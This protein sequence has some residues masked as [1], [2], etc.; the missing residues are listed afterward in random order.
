MSAVNR[1]WLVVLGA[2]GC[3][4]VFDIDRTRPLDAAIPIDAQYF[5]AP[6]DARPMCPPPGSAPA[7]QAGYVQLPVGN[8]ISYVPAPDSGDA[9]TYC[10]TGPKSYIQQGPIDQGVSE[11]QLSPPPPTT[12]GT[13]AMPRVSADGQVLFVENTATGNIDVFHRTADG[14]WTTAS[15]SFMDGSYRFVSNATRGPLRR[16]IQT[17]LDGVNMTYRFFELE[18]QP[19][20]AWLPIEEHPVTDIGMSYIDTVSLS[21]DGRHMTLVGQVKDSTKMGVYWTQRPDLASDFGEVVELT[22][23]PPGGILTPYITEDCSRIYF[24]ALSTVFYQKL[25]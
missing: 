21:P 11:A 9:V 18:E 17:D 12:G 22:T 14:T 3:N 6:P 2:S 15:Q 25:Q 19:S 10:F 13:Y 16:A 7:F 1:C 5:D 8:C 23:V 24:S 20:G 4:W